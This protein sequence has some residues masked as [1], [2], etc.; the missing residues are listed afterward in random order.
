[1]SRLDWAEVFT[2]EN[3]MPIRY[4]DGSLAGTIEWSGHQ[5]HVTRPD[6]ETVRAW[7]LDGGDTIQI[8]VRTAIAQCDPSGALEWLWPRRVD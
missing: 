2:L 4:D 3:P 6:G 1:M 8:L 5:A 7:D